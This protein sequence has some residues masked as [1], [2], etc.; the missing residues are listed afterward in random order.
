VREAWIVEG[1]FDK[2]SGYNGFHALQQQA[3]LPEI[4]FAANDRI[5]QGAFKA[6]KEAGLRIPED[7]G[8]I[9]L[10]HNEF[11]ENL[12]PSLTI[13]DAP[14]DVIGQRAMEILVEEMKDP[15]KCGQHH[16]VLETSMKIHGSIG[17]KSNI[18][19]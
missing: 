13:M 10:G 2:A 14:P 18:V 1:G 8:V 9:A 5:A 15:S 16:I 11:A 12:S 4:V 3:E 17:N 19:K 7:I 6:I